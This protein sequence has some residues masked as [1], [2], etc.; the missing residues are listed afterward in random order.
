MAVQGS[1]LGVRFL[2]CIVRRVR[3]EAELAIF[4]IVLLSIGT[5]VGQPDGFTGFLLGAVLFAL[6]T[7]ELS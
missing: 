7:H 6:V 1:C 3:S 5:E 2:D 4:V